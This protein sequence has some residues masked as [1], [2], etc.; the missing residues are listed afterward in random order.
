MIVGLSL[1]L[2]IRYSIQNSKRQ[3]DRE[4]FD[5]NVWATSFPPK[6]EEHW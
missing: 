3:L 1:H 6:D 5:A 4:V 2:D